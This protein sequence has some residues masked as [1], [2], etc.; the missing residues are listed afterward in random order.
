MAEYTRR[1]LKEVCGLAD[2][3]T[4]EE[5]SLTSEAGVAARYGIT[6]APAIA[7]VGTRD[8]GIRFYGMPAGYEF[9]T[10]VDVI[11]DVSTGAAP[12]TPQTREALATL[13]A[14]AHLQVFVTP[15]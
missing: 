7:V 3:I 13:Q 12:V 10:F 14:P 15:T 5:H 1:L 9:A 8:D 4:L 11:V 2:R 6:R